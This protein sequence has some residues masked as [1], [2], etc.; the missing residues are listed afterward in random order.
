MQKASVD[1]MELGN[2]LYGNSRG[3][4]SMDRTIFQPM[5]QEFLDKI[6]V[7]TYGIP[8]KPQSY[9]K[10]GTPTI[11]TDKF[12]IRP[13]YW[14]DDPEIQALPNFVYKPMQLQICWYKYTLRDAYS[15]HDLTPDQMQAILND[16]IASVKE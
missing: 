6:H 15:S 11:E 3:Q 1:T 2:L 13:Y 16:C 9:G 4:F 12:L 7:D 8:E 14:G 10:A 5:F